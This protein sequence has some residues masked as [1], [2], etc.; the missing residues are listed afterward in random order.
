MLYDSLEIQYAVSVSQYTPREQNMQRDV[1]ILT[2]KEVSAFVPTS[3]QVAVKMVFL[4]NAPERLMA[5]VTYASL[6][7]IE[8]YI[9]P[10]SIK[11]VRRWADDYPEFVEWL[12]APDSCDVALQMAKTKALEVI[13]DLLE[14]DACDL[15]VNASL[16]G[17][18]MKA[19][20]FILKGL[21]PKKTAPINKN[22][23]MYGRIPKHL[24]SKSEDALEA[25]LLKLERAK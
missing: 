12:L 17:I 3:R 18:K 8:Q 14:L 24:A 15:E 13:K 9:A 16:L 7:S 11:E 10:Y 6:D 19:A 22:L 4:R 5:T 20:E 1:D 21:E 23:A 25:E 2:A